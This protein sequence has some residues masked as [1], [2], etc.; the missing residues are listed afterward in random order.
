MGS[1]PSGTVPETSPKRPNL[2]RAEDNHHRLGL[3][4]PKPANP[5]ANYVPA[6]RSGQLL[7]IAGQLAL[8]PEGRIDP[9]HQG[10]VGAQVSPEDGY[11]AA[12]L[13]AIQILAQ[14]AAATGSLDQVRRCVRVTGYVAC[15]PGFSTLAGVINGAS[16]LMVAVFG[17]QGRH[18]RS[19]VGAAQL[20]LNSCVE[21]EAI[22]E[23][24]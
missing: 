6:V 1:L 10:L 23:V 20:P 24:V 19:A 7:F 17:D 8:G 21:I 11:E 12:R 3:I 18:A 15:A 4:L 14:V 16:D 5:L 9:A 22:F 2:I 13:C